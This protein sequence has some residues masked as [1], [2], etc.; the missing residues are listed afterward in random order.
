MDFDH[1]FTTTH[2]PNP[3]LLKKEKGTF[4]AS[5]DRS[6]LLFPREGGRGMSCMG[7]KNHLSIPIGAR[8]KLIESMQSSQLDI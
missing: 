8:N 7:P 6:P 3:L 4:R 2:P 1:G 5:N